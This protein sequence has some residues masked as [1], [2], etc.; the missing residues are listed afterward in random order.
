MGNLGLSLLSVLSALSLS[1]P[2]APK[3]KLCYP[4]KHQPFSMRPHTVKAAA[5]RPPFAWQHT[6][7]RHTYIII[8]SPPFWPAGQA[9]YSPLHLLG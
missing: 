4:S 7:Y 3:L 8:L 9:A 6:P 5:Q 1:L 2:M